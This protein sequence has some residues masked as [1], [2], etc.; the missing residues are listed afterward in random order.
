MAA[1]LSL[2]GGTEDA[3]EIV[4]ALLTA[5]D[6]RDAH[7]PIQAVRWR[8]LAEAIGDALDAL[9]KPKQ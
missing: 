4:E 6:T 2:P 9:P 1:L 5:A 3:A 7:A 8:A